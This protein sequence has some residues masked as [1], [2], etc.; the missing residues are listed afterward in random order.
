MARSPVEGHLFIGIPDVIPDVDLLSAYDLW[1]AF[2]ED[3]YL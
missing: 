1:K 2:R 3:F